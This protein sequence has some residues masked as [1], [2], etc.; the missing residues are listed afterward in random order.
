MRFGCHIASIGGVWAGFVPLHVAETQR[1]P[2]FSL[3]KSLPCERN[4]RCGTPNTLNGLF[5]SVT[6]HWWCDGYLSPFSRFR[7][8]KGVARNLLNLR[9]GAV[10]A[11][12]PMAMPVA[13]PM[14]VRMVEV[15]C[16]CVWMSAFNLFDCNLNSNERLARQWLLPLWPPGRRRRRRSLPHSL[17]HSSPRSAPLARTPTASLQVRCAHAAASTHCSGCAARAQQWQRRS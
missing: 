4:A 13:M 3:K 17:V 12:T 10:Y 7:I 6:T 9:A 14:A 15:M 11:T 16:V 8:F 5:S 1:R 2:S